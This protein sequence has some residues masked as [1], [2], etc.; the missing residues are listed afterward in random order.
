M[1]P[2]LLCVIIVLG[3]KG[4]KDLRERMH[5]QFFES[6]RNLDL[7]RKELGEKIDRTVDV[8]EGSVL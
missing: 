4:Y 1:T 7:L 5:L 8:I 6:Q 3:Y 2:I